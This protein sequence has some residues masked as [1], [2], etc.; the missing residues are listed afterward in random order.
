MQREDSKFQ[1][2]FLHGEVLWYRLETLKTD[3]MQHLE[4]QASC[5][6][7]MTCCV[8]E[9]MLPAQ[10]VKQQGSQHQDGI[11]KAVQPES[12]LQALA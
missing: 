6:N 11:T 12:W 4:L 8:H 7:A 3:T 9:Q 2:H 1:L 5:C 10:L